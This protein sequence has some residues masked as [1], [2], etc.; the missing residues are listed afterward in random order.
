MVINVSIKYKPGI[1]YKFKYPC[2]N[3]SSCEPYFVK[4]SPGYYR[5]QLWG[6][7]RIGGGAYVK[8]DRATASNES[9]YI[10]VGGIGT[11]FGPYHGLGGYNGGGSTVNLISTGYYRGY[12][13]DGATDIR[14]IETDRSSRIIVAGG[15]GARDNSLKNGSFAGGLIGADGIAYS[16]S[17]VGKGGN[18]TS[19]GSGQYNGAFGIGA[20]SKPTGST[21]FAG[22]GGGGWFGGGSG[23]HNELYAAGGGGSSYISGF[24]G[25]TNSNSG[26]VFTKPEMF[27]GNSTIAEPD[28]NISEIGHVGSGYVIISCLSFYELSCGN[29]ESTRWI[30]SSLPLYVFVL[31]E[32]S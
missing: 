4:Q 2:E 7:G 32:D 13:G 9:F 26:I 21:D 25:C 27:D 12:P 15:A 8:G 5:Y 1:S 18:Q 17:I 6:P 3:Q 30:I 20:D 23:Y 16:G 11:F 24:E 14:L 28:G 22:A 19:G 29:C 10:F 31:L